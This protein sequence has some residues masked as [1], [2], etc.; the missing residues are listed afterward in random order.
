MLTKTFN[1]LFNFLV[2]WFK[3]ETYLGSCQTSR[4]RRSPLDILCKKGVLINFAKFT[5]K[6]LCQSLFFNKVSGP[7]GY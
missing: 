3:P 4:I 2:C 1:K 6:Y 5:G 7:E